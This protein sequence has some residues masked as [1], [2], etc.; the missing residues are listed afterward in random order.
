MISSKRLQKP[1]YNYSVVSKKASRYRYQIYKDVLQHM[2]YSPFNRLLLKLDV[3][4]FIRRQPKTHFLT[5]KEEN[6]LHLRRFLISEHYNTLRWYTN[7]EHYRSMKTRLNGGSKSFSSRAYNQQF[8]GTFKKIRH[9]FA[10]TPSQGQDNVILKFDQALY[11]DGKNT[12]T[13]PLLN[14]IIIHEEL[15]PLNNEPVT[16]SKNGDILNQSQ[17]IV[18]TYLTDSRE[19]RDQ[20]IK[21]L[22]NDKNYTKLTQFLYKGQKL[23]GTEP[24]T[25]QRLL[26]LQEKEALLTNDEKRDIEKNLKSLKLRKFMM[27]NN[28][29]EDLYVTYLKNWKRKMNDQEALRNYL[30]RR[31]E[32]R[33][34][35]KQNK[36]KHLLNKLKRLETWIQDS[37]TNSSKT[38]G[39]SMTKVIP[40]ND[41]L[42]TGLQKAIFEGMTTLNN[43][44]T[45]VQKP[46]EKTLWKV[47]LLSSIKEKS[48]ATVSSYKDL[49]V[50]FSDL[51]LKKQTNVLNNIKT[52]TTQLQT[53]VKVVNQKNPKS[54]SAKKS[55]LQIQTTTANVYSRFKKS[56]T[57]YLGLETLTNLF[58]P[59]KRKSLKNWRQKEQASGRQK[60]SRKD[61]KM[62]NKKSELKND[63]TILASDRNDI[64]L[65]LQT[66]FATGALE[67][68]KKRDVESQVSTTAGDASQIQ[69]TQSR[70]FSL[71]FGVGTTEALNLENTSFKRKR[72][73]QRR[74]R[75][76]RSRGVFKKRTLSDS[77]KKDIKRFVKTKDQLSIEDKTA[78]FDTMNTNLYSITSSTAKDTEA[79]VPLKQRKSKQRKQRYWKQK[80]SKYAQKRRKYRKRKRY[81][82]GKIR[83]LSKQLKRVKNK[84][85]IQNW[86]W[87]QFVPSIQASTDALWQIEKDKFIQQ[88]LSELSS[89]EILERDQMFN[90]SML[91]IGNKDFKP[92]ATPE[93]MR[94]KEK[95]TSNQ[96]FA[97]SNV[98]TS[99]NKIDN[100][101]QNSS[102]FDVVNKLYENLF[103]SNSQGSLQ[104]PQN[105][106]FMT[107]NTMLPFYAGWDESLR[108]FVVTNRMLS[109]RDA[110][111]EMNQVNNSTLVPAL[112]PLMDVT[113]QKENVL[114]NIEFSQAPV[115]GMNAA[116]TLY[117]QIP[118]TTYD[119]DQFFA[120]GMDGFSPIGWR[121]FL[122]RHSILKTWLNTANDSNSGWG[123]SSTMRNPV[124]LTEGEPRSETYGSLVIQSKTSL[125]N[126]LKEKSMTQL[127]KRSERTFDA[128]NATRRLKK[129][130]RRVKKHPRTPV[131]FPSGPLLNQVLPV[132]YIYVFY[133]RSR[134]PR[135]RYLKRRLLN[136]KAINKSEGLKTLR[137]FEGSP[138]LGY[139][140]TLRK[141]LKPKRK[142]HLK[143]DF[144]ASNVVI[145]R[146]FKFITAP[147]SGDKNTDILASSATAKMWR[148]LSS[149]KINKP[150]VE[151]VKEQ[152][153]LR[154]KQRRK[155]PSSKQQTPL[156]RVKQLRRRVQRQ[157][158][159]SI[160]RYRPR[161][162]GFVWPGDYL[163]L[164]L[165]KAPK[166]QA[167]DLQTPQVTEMTAKASISTTAGRGKKKKKRTLV[168]WQIQPKKY[169]Y[170]KHN[171]KVLKKKLEKAFRAD[172]MQQKIQEMN[173]KL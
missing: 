106:P 95:L 135:D 69:P 117:W 81:A 57:Q 143:R 39:G 5:Q 54:N 70:G 146:R 56:L 149:L 129:R 157:I 145:P 79:T 55:L 133:K 102:N 170:E 115:Q 3:D 173:Y 127:F 64:E 132:H 80:R 158:L 52:S 150:I 24:A 46:T 48:Q 88:K 151:L 139:D 154:S 125:V 2:Y 15:L 7:M 152:K 26:N 22:L 8:A 108:K 4:S 76:R 118:F 43:V 49:P 19:Y 172:S 13:N 147:L 60:R 119:P 45:N 123:T 62:L 159:R 111:F 98:S 73:P 42:T 142:Y 65:A 171:I 20:Y 162:G 10:I 74:A 40:Q 120:L 38:S 122:F 156:L 86:W 130:Y 66:S 155:D 112:K 114:M 77:L 126:T 41:I 165:V 109:R 99:V 59:I 29:L 141:R 87:K 23:R 18:R 35:H 121:K 34:K 61:F 21:N 85:E 16:N 67:G 116:T 166:L 84:I 124:G 113:A 90:S 25:N 17:N 1:T 14:Q 161:S 72:S 63:S 94:L 136:T 71:P 144:Y 91:Q 82:V 50:R 32:K 37:Q 53:L 105:G 93:A 12:S 51:N 128:K 96:T 89:A 104:L 75:V 110:G 97:E 148:P 27:D 6:L 30:T 68:R 47:L 92:L 100:S 169:L 58:K 9:L 163:K 107:P 103:I 11:N 101:P 168:E 134:L 138:Y 160:W 33:E 83:I 36:E 131:W 153:L 28:L 137:S 140:F 164:E 31:V 44:D 167:P 78:F